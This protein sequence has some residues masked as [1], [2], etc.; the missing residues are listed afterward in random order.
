MYGYF[1]P[2][3]PSVQKGGVGLNCVSF[4]FSNTCCDKIPL[5]IRAHEIG[6]N[7]GMLHSSGDWAEYGAVSHTGPAV[8]Y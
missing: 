7:W 5:S 4:A 8:S 2:N 3:G 6:H 1:Q